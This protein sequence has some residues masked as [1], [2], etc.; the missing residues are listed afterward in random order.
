MLCLVLLV[1]APRLLW[2]SDFFL[3]ASLQRHVDQG[4]L[5]K[6]VR[7]KIALHG[8]SEVIVIFDENAESPPI[9]G[10]VSSNDKNVP[11]LQARVMKLTDRKKRLLSALSHKKDVMELTF[12]D[13]FP[14]MHLEMDGAALAD[15]LEQP[16]VLSVHE[17]RPL[18]HFLAQSLPLI[19]APQVHSAGMTGSGTSVAVLDT[20]INYTLA[21]FGGCSA[22]GVPASCKVV[23]AQDFAPNDGSPDDDGHG[24]NVAGIVAGVAPD[25][26]L[27]ALDVFRTDGYA[28]YS[29]LL[30]ALNWVVGN[31]STYN[32]V[33]VNMS[34]G[35]GSYSSPCNTD[36]LANA[37]ATLKSL[38]VVTVIASGNDAFD[39]AI[40]SPAC[41]PGAVSVGAVYDADIGVIHTSACTDNNTAADKTTCFSN[42]AGFMSIL[43]PGAWTT[44]AGYTYAGTSQATPHVA[45]AVAVLKGAHPS[46]TADAVSG[47]LTAS[48]D[49]ITTVRS[50]TYVKPRLNLEA[51]LNYPDIG[52]SPAGLD[53][54]S[55][56]VG[57]SSPVSAVTITNNGAT[58]LAVGQISRTGSAAD[59]FAIDSDYCSGVSLPAAS[60]C[61]VGVRFRP[62]AAGILSTTLL[63][64]SDDPDPPLTVP[65]SG[66]GINTVAT[67]AVS[68][69]GTGSGTVTSQ[70]SGIDCGTICGASFT[71]GATVTLAPAAASDSL[72][73]GWQASCSGTGPCQITMTSDLP[74]SAVFNLKPP[75]LMNAPSP[76][77][78]TTLAAAF[79]VAA[80]G[81][82]I[83]AKAVTFY[84]NLLLDRNISV[85]I[86]GGYDDAYGAAT[87]LSSIY[88]TLTVGA[89]TLSVANLVIL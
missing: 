88:G 79:A 87:G 27:I 75:V 19:R 69:S 49:G 5:A 14:V 64:S 15:L 61:T 40:S 48:G 76:G 2:G 66:T 46:L 29:D 84:E 44:A 77:Y 33:S 4:R 7:D 18:R 3:N 62:T 8:R 25:T 51:A 21:A 31:R 74:V 85:T 45:G 12:Y 37:V 67:L 81:A 34:L 26:K 58:S 16:E 22:P 1:A 57:G 82:T 78:Y 56:T 36:P 72:F 54:G 83:Q 38:G 17:N 65:L 43:A 11:P 55:V 63:I 60:S 41:V 42:M 71:Q 80:D 50:V 6:E 68:K 89:G 24:T 86:S 59:Q 28:Y 73:A 23:Y 53:L 47:R 39:G 30:S 13:H 52:V 32:I 10:E 9:A 20:G 35:G 70:P